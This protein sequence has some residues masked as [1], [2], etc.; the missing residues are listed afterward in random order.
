M[1]ID[2][3]LRVISDVLAE[4]GKLGLP[5]GPGRWHILFGGQ[6]RP[7][8]MPAGEFSQQKRWL[9]YFT[10]GRLRTLYAMTLLKLNAWVPSMRLLPELKVR[11]PGRVATRRR[12]PIRPDSRAPGPQAA[13][14]IGT[15]GPYQKA[16]AL[17][18]SDRGEGLALAKIALA[19]SAD[20]MVVAEAN[21]LRALGGLEEFAGDVPR[22]LAEGTIA[23]GRRYLV[24]S[25]APS[26]HV[27]TDF[28]S[29]HA[30]FVAR[31]GRSC[32]EIIQFDSSPCCQFLE[33]T[34]AEVTPVLRRS[35]SMELEDALRD[36]R[37]LLRG[38]RGPFV[39]SQG[40]FA[41]W[42]IRTRPG[43][44][45]VFDWEYARRGANPLADL[46]HFHL[47]QRA[48][49]GR[50]VSMKYLAS[51]LRRAMAFARER[52]PESH[53]RAP[54][55][56]ALALAYLLDVLLYYTR[57]SGGFDGEE[58]VMQGYWSLIERR[59]AWMAA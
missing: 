50:T 23:N 56:S 14:Q 15:K 38:H 40:D 13:I 35:Q 49:A 11:G 47:I 9:P 48:A 52:Y 58:R 41:W 28:T 53:W 55:V 24:T 20:P 16:S 17:L 19:E 18:I 57:A 36:C 30:D 4:S 54:G 51:V 43:G 45:F 37:R 21:W 34:L 25:L 10:G 26:T 31:L 42:N 8:L 32:M 39:F 3:P 22:L 33:H 6:Q 59:S 7:L 46:F 44:I 12:C 5:V 2:E 1:N 27:T 29:A